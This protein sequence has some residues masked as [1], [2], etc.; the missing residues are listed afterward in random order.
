MRDVPE[1]ATLDPAHIRFAL[2]EANL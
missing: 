1:E 2:A